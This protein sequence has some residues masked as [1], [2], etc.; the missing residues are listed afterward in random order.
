[1]TNPCRGDADCENDVSASQVAA[2]C[3]IQRV[4]RGYRTRKE[5]QGRHLTATNRWIDVR[6]CTGRGLEYN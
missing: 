4:Y 5:L 3:L 6:P 1:M 2:V